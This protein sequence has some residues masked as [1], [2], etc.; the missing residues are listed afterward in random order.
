MAAAHSCA[1]HGAPGAALASALPRV[2]FLVAPCPHDVTML[3][4]FFLSSSCGLSAADSCKHQSLSVKGLTCQLQPAI[5][6]ALP[7]A[8]MMTTHTPGAIPSL[9]RQLPCQSDRPEVGVLTPADKVCYCRY[10]FICRCITCWMALSGSRS[11]TPAPVKH[12]AD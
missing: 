2:T 3:L 9:P 5:A 4:L 7:S 1:H 11:T 10:Y 8:I 6:H 12:T